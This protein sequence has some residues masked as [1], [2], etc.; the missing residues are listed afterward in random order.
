MGSVHVCLIW[1]YGNTQFPDPPMCVAAG[2]NVTR[3][4]VHSERGLDGAVPCMMLVRVL[5]VLEVCGGVGAAIRVIWGIFWRIGLGLK[6]GAEVAERT[7]HEW[8]DVYS[9]AHVAVICAGCVQHLGRGTC[10]VTRR[11]WTAMANC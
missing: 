6:L 9:C 11:R 4:T 7:S 3:C 5:G 8:L 10:E 2:R 1:M